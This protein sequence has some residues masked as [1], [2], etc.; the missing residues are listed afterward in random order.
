MH[1]HLGTNRRNEETDAHL[2]LAIYTRLLKGFILF[3]PTLF[4]SLCSSST[5]WECSYIVAL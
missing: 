3:T 1:G 2:A 5:E 4:L